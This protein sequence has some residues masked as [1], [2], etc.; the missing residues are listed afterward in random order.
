MARRAVGIEVNDASIRVVALRR[1]RRGAVV[2][3]FASVDHH[4]AVS[5]TAVVDGAAYREALEE[6]LGR[7]KAGRSHLC[8]AVACQEVDMRELE[9]PVMPERDLE[10]T[11]R[12]ELANVVRFG[13]GGEE[14]LL[15]DYAPIPGD[16]QGGRRRLISVAVPRHVVRSYL[17][18][19]YAVGIYPEIL[20]MGAFSLPWACPREG[21]VCYV[22]TT[23]GGAHVL[24]YESQ[25]FR[26]TRV[27]NVNLASLVA[28]AHRRR[29]RGEASLD[30][31][32]AV[33]AFEELALAV[34][35]TLD[36][37]R[38]RRRGASITDLID[39]LVISGELGR[40]AQ[41]ALE[42]GRRIGIPATAAD[43]IIGPGDAHTF[44]E[45]APLYAVAC[46]MAARGLERL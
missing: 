25:E 34:E 30:A 43:P 27:V 40:D 31:P 35:R 29:E 13:K 14:E 3:G 37:H 32:L 16:Q 19:L 33:R 18:P 41:L 2:D 9:F 23:G 1:G 11:I 44:G 46:G 38:A 7:A 36:Y 10:Y 20:E 15:F 4:G 22:H 8:I 21:G 6:A 39:G 28:E 12:F 24:I 17:D 42:F 5:A 45:D 26:L